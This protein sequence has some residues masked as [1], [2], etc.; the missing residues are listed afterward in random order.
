MWPDPTTIASTMRG[1][2]DTIF[3]F[4][5]PGS[6]L[7]FLCYCLGINGCCNTTHLDELNGITGN[8]N[9]VIQVTDVNLL[10]TQFGF[11]IE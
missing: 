2:G 11:F 5:M 1:S 7:I 3:A 6:R 8:P 10:L 9:Q 4:A